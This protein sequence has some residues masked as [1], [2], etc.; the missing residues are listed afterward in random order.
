MYTLSS[1]QNNSSMFGRELNLILY[2]LQETTSVVE[3]KHLVDEILLFITGRSIPI[4]E[5][6]NWLDPPQAPLLPHQ[7]NHVQFL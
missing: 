4:N 6:V 2:G 1:S 3:S 5:L 7:G